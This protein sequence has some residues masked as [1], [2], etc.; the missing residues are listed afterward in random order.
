MKKINRKALLSISAMMLMLNINS[1]PLFTKVTQKAE[2]SDRSR[3]AKQVNGFKYKTSKVFINTDL[4]NPVTSELELNLTSELTL[5]ADRFST[6][7][8]EKG[9]RGIQF[10]HY[11]M[12]CVCCFI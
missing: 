4:I 2:F 3:T 9:D 7:I 8:T 1:E 12:Y 5:F 6:E 10:Y 11:I